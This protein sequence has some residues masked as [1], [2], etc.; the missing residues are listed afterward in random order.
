MQALHLAMA[1]RVAVVM[2]IGVVAACGAN[3]P[4]TTAAALAPKADFATDE[5]LTAAQSVLVKQAVQKM[6]PQP[7]TVRL[8]AVNGKTLQGKEGFHV[9]GYASGGGLTGDTPFYVELRQAARQW[10][11]HR[12]QVGADAARL[13]KVRFVC[14]HH[15]GA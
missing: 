3:P 8:S 13:A 15:D 5:N 9:C 14:R 10:T 7:E 4:A 1:K 11:S 6:L 2:A 12:G